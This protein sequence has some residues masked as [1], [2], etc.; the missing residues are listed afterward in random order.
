MPRFCNFIKKRL[1]HDILYQI[2]L[3]KRSSCEYCK[4]FKNSF[5]YRTPSV[6]TFGYSNA[7]HRRYFEKLLQ[8]SKGNI[9][10]NSVSVYTKRLCPATKIEIHHRFSY[11]ILQDFRTASFEINFL[12]GLIL[13]K[14]IEEEKDVKWPL[15]LQVFTFFHGS[16]LLSHE[17]MFFLYK[18]SYSG[19]I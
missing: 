12:G 16:Y 8:N 14:Q 7:I 11:E 1:Q 2:S 4:I 17:T 6:A 5:F 9:L 3:S 18:L 15:W 13:K 19:A 10:H